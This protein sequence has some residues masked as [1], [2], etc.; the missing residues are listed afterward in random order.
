M[1]LDLDG[2][3]LSGCPSLDMYYDSSTRQCLQCS[4][5]CYSCN[6]PL[7]SNCLS[8][9]PPLQLYQGTC[10]SGC[11]FGHYSTTSYICQPCNSNCADCAN[12]ST[13]CTVCQEGTFL[14]FNSNGLSV[15]TIECGSG[16]YP[17]LTA[18]ICQNCNS[19][20][21]NCSGPSSS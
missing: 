7:S 21:L 15:C 12:S 5:A 10:L 18:S 3:C 1:I 19:S 13:N 11:P 20:C 2:N 8:C 9:L 16:F 17:D 4:S 6:G 14:H